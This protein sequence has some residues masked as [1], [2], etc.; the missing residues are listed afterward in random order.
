MALTVAAFNKR[1]KEKTDPLY[2]F[3]G[4][5]R[6]ILSAYI[7]RIKSTVMPDDTFAG[8]N[9]SVLEGKAAAFDDFASELSTYPQMADYKL[10]ILK[11]TDFLSGAEY[12]KP[13]HSLLG[14]LPDYAVV[15]FVEEDVKKIK[16][17]T[18]KLIESK[19]A[20]VEFARQSNADL[21]AWVGR[22][23][24]KYRKKMY[25]EDIEYLI[26]ICDRSL[27]RLRVECDK[28]IAAAGDGEVITRKTVTELVHVPLEYKIYTMADKL[29]SGDA[30]SAYQMLREL[31]LAKEQ[32]TVVISLIYSQLATLYM[33]QRLS[34]RAE[35]YLP[36]N[37]KFLARQYAA[38]CRA[39]DAQMLRSMMQKCAESDDNIKRGRI[40]GW[41]A[42]ELIM[43]SLLHA[44]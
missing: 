37:R 32:P 4:E 13:L 29:L 18:L 23:L 40:D 20:V 35:D 5:E 14:D 25:T 22:E 21:R 28:L 24:A 16:K 11:N 2:L 7:A 15:I 33:F 42:L 36:P 43:A 44:V 41:T 17:D 9:F 8:F 1:L 27:E 10:I 38:R 34:N 6:F 39:F 12:Q 19:G 31:K 26:G 3:Y 30:L